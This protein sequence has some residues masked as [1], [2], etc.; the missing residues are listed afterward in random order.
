LIALTQTLAHHR[1]LVGDA[2]AQHCHQQ[3]SDRAAYSRSLDKLERQ[4]FYTKK[5]MEILF[6][7][8]SN[9]TVAILAE[10]LLHYIYE[11]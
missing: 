8:I 5:S 3:M 2:I 11:G 10:V 6:N 7:I 1:L 4:A 9:G